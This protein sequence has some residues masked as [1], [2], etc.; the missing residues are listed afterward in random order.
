[1]VERLLEY[2]KFKEAASEMS[3]YEDH[4]RKMYSR[5]FFVKPQDDQPVSNEEYLQ[6]VS[7]FDLLLAFK[8]ALDNMPKVTYHEVKKIEV[9]IEEQTAYIL[10]TL[11]KQSSI[12]F[13]ELIALFKD[14]IVIIVTFLALLELIKLH[15]IIV[16]Q[17]RVFEEIEISIA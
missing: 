15:K 14:K 9:T 17:A 6:N 12:L 8:K 7:L 2:K 3:G 5:K 16:R 1:L 4:R 13:S 11:E 10:D